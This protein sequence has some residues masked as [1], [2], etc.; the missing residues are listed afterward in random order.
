MRLETVED[1]Y[2]ISLPNRRIYI[3]QNHDAELSHCR[4]VASVDVGSNFLQ[5]A[6]NAQVF[7]VRWREGSTSRAAGMDMGTVQDTHWAAPGESPSSS[8]STSWWPLKALSGQ[9]PAMLCGRGLGARVSQ[10]ACQAQLSNKY[11]F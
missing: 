11:G 4:Q 8:S 1:H 7:Q 6:H 3:L 2:H 10:Q 9:G 5:P